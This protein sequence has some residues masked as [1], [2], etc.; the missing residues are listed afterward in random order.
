M[1]KIVTINSPTRRLE[2]HIQITALISACFWGHLWL[3]TVSNNRGF[4]QK[5]GRLQITEKLTLRGYG[6][7]K[8]QI[9]RKKPKETEK[10]ALVVP[11]G[12]RSKIGIQKSLNF[13]SNLTTEYSRIGKSRNRTLLRWNPRLDTVNDWDVNREQNGYL[14]RRFSSHRNRFFLIIPNME[15]NMP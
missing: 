7:R 4:H 12:N 10:M 1:F 13:Q 2:W 5:N 15:K 6:N 9:L 11:V 3:A 14:S 8:C